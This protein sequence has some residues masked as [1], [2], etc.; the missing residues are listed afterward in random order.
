MPSPDAVRFEIALYV[1][2]EHVEKVGE[3]IDTADDR[4][5]LLLHI[6]KLVG[7]LLADEPMTD[8]DYG[9]AE[10]GVGV[11]EVYHEGND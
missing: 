10:S 8:R 9:Y 1:E 6:E 4:K 7:A 11:A 5:S 3:L 2:P